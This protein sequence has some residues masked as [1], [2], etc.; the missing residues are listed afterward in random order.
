MKKTIEELL[1][2]PYWIIDILP[3]RVPDDS[4][5]RYFALEPYFLQSPDTARKKLGLILKLNCYRDLRY[6]TQTEI[7]DSPTAA[8]LEDWVKNT[9]L[10]I[11]VD[12]AMI[13]SDPSDHYM[14][15][16]GPEK[17]LLDLL[18]ALAA[19]EGLSVW[20]PEE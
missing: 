2:S 17:E 3:F 4:L 11:L 7:S 15:V 10:N 12:G 8:Q 6:I 1:Q 9:Y 14:T 16:Y 5:G 18:R 20:Q 13:V 19:T